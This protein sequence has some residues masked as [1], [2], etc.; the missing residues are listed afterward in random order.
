MTTT[1]TEAQRRYDTLT[2]RIAAI[3]ED[4]GR[5]LDGERRLSL[6]ARRDD[7]VKERDAVQ[8][9]L[10]ANDKRANGDLEV[11]QRRVQDLA[12]VLASDHPQEAHVIID[13][14]VSALSRLDKRVL[15]LEG[16]V[17]AIEREI[18]PPPMVQVWR[19]AA[20]VVLVFGV[21]VGVWQR[22]VFGVYPVIGVIVEAVLVMLAVAC[23]MLASAKLREARP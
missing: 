17:S 21:I 23:V 2:K 15:G 5:E 1:P 13:E 4:I 6:E 20:A 8:S 14:C 7:L 11:L 16:R 3:D 19:A 22:Q 18:H 12:R 10:T 9:Q